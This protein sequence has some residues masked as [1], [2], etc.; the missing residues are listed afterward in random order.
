MTK[1]KMT[2]DKVR[3]EH[4]EVGGELTDVR[5]RYKKAHENER[6]AENLKETIENTD[7]PEDFRDS[8]RSKFAHAVTETREEKN[9]LKDELN[10]LEKKTKELQEI[11]EETVKDISGVKDDIS[12]V[13]TKD[14]DRGIIL[15]LRQNLMERSNG[16]LGEWQHQA[17]DFANMNQEINDMKDNL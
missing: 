6:L 11:S 12:K 10:N 17:G 15:K 2:I 16:E 5:N 8:L 14:D 13:N 3:K 1:N 9:K 4:M 7:L